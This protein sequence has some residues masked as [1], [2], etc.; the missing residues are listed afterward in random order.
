M[1]TYIGYRTPEHLVAFSFFITACGGIDNKNTAGDGGGA[2]TQ[3][4]AT[5]ESP[6]VAVSSQNANPLKTPGKGDNY[7]GGSSSQ[8]I[9]ESLGSIHPQK[10]TDH[11]VDLLRNSTIDAH[12]YSQGNAANFIH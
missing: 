5:N 3:M 1:D 2:N 9:F 12:G 4:S 10:L 8:N 11:N 7:L 6:T